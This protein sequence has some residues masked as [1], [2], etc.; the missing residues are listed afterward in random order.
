[1][2]R[3]R[4]II[5]VAAQL[6]ARHG[7]HGTSVRDLSEALGLGKASLYHHIESKDELLF[8]VH[9]Q[10]INP[11]LEET[12]R[13]LSAEMDPRDALRTLSCILMRVIADY[14]P[15]V[16]VFLNEWRALSPERAAAIREKR[17]RF[18][19][20]IRAALQRGVE[21]GLFRPLDVS[22]T[23]LGFLG[24]HN[25]AYQWLNPEGRLSPEEIAATFSSIFLRGIA[26]GDNQSQAP[27][28]SASPQAG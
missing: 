5:E 26:Q 10:F 9:E 27:A 28:T 17:K 22:V 6:F 20:Y 2:A 21:Q 4:D 12:E 19:G 25:Y 14:R 8:W 11:L 18:E 16:T 23:C 7:Y 3:K 15:Y 13:R 1:M 24:M